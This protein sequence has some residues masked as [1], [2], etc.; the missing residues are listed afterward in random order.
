[1]AREDVPRLAVL[2]AAWAGLFLF[3]DPRGQFPL[4]DD[5]QYAECARRLVAG[6]GMHLP[7]WALSATAA[8]ALLGAVATAP[9]GATNQALRFWEILI[10]G[11]GAALVY[12]LARRWRA[13]ADVAF[14]AALTV[15]WSPLYATLSASFHIDVTASAFTLAGLLAFLHA[16]ERRAPRWYAAASALVA[17]SGLSRQTGFLCVAGGLAALSWERRLSRR[18][19][20]AFVLPA[21]LAA[22]AFAWWVRCVHGPTWAWESGVYSPKADLDYWLRPA[23]RGVVLARFGK[24]LSMTALFLAPLSLLRARGTFARKTTRGEAVAL[25][26]VAAAGLLL[27]AKDRGLPLLLNTLT[28]AGLGAGTLVDA[29][30]KPGGWWRSPL[31]WN[32]AALTALLS[33]LILTRAAAE[34]NRGPDAEELRAAALFA[35]APYLPALVMPVIYDRYLLIFLP[36]AAAGFA[37][38]RRDDARRAAPAFAAAAILGFFTWAGLSDYFAWN[39]ARWEAGTTAARGKPTASVENGFDWDGQF[40]LTRNLNELRRRKPARKIGVWEWQTLNRVV[41]GTCFK[42]TPKVPGWKLVGEF[43]YRTPLLPGRGGVVR[44]FAAPGSVVEG[45][46]PRM[47]E[48]AR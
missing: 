47:V 28:R 39:R 48:H 23:A 37:A 26:A 20:A 24:T 27:W 29:D 32:A 46:A 5:F 16:R 42:A 15:A 9:W 19:A 38:G 22:A 25:A 2:A 45:P 35:F 1:M 40:S 12:A 33:S 30:D 34:E 13:G 41:L 7:Q 17:V 36:V 8:H 18:E 14:L 44:L 31:L 4:N 43:P 6:E 3:V 21:A 11:A 10:G